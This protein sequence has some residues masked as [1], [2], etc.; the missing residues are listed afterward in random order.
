MYPFPP[1]D[2]SWVH[3]QSGKRPESGRSAKDA[4][5]DTSFFGFQDPGALP[6]STKQEEPRAMVKVLLEQPA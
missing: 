3:V 4:Q 6:F 5:M 2:R 1:V